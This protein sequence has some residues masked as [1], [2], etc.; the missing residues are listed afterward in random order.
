MM[1][2]Y[3]RLTDLIITNPTFKFHSADILTEMVKHRD[4]FFILFKQLETLKSEI[5]EIDTSE[6]IEV[7]ED[8][9]PI[10]HVR[11]KI[12]ITVL[13]LDHGY[14]DIV[15]KRPDV[16]YKRRGVSIKVCSPI[17]TLIDMRELDNEIK[18]RV[19]G[20]SL[21]IAVKNAFEVFED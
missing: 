9:D 8:F 16:S 1:N 17:E 20:K 13:T 21:S 2:Y 7:N 12:T 6:K 11:T 5:G 15:Y 10:T 4:F 19:K 14:I 18:I 3:D